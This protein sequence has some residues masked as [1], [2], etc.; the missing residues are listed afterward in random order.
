MHT[1]VPSRILCKYR[2]V[3]I[4]ILQCV[5]IVTVIATTNIDESDRIVEDLLSTTTTTQTASTG[6]RYNSDDG[7]YQR[8]QQQLPPPSSF[9]GASDLSTRVSSRCWRTGIEIIQAAMAPSTSSSFYSSGDTNHDNNSRM[10]IATTFCAQMTELEFKRLALEIAFC[11]MQDANKS[12]YQNMSIQKVCTT[13]TTTTSMTMNVETIQMCLSHLTDIGYHT[14]TYFLPYVEI[15]CTRKTQELFLQQQ[16][17]MI[18]T[19]S[20]N[21]AHMTQQTNDQYTAHIQQVQSLLEA[22]TNLQEY[23]STELKDQFDATKTGLDVIVQDQMTAWNGHVKSMVEAI[24]ERNMEYQNQMDDWTNY[25]SSMLLQHSYEMEHHR[26]LLY[27]QEVKVQHLSNTIEQSTIHMQPLFQLQSLLIMATKGYDWVT[28]FIHFLG[29]LNIVWVVTRFRQCE[30]FR[31][32]LFGF[33]YTEAV[34]EI[35]LAF[36]VQYEILSNTDRIQYI[37]E[38]RQWEIMVVIFTYVFGIIMSLWSPHH[39]PKLEPLDVMDLRREITNLISKQC[40]VTATEQNHDDMYADP[41]Y[42]K[43]VDRNDCFNSTMQYMSQQQHLHE[44]KSPLQQQR[45]FGYCSGPDPLSTTTNVSSFRAVTVEEIKNADNVRTFRTLNLHVPDKTPTGN[46]LV[47][48]HHE[49]TSTNESGM[50]TGVNELHLI[51][52]GKSSQIYQTYPPYEYTNSYVDGL[53]STPFDSNNTA[54]TPNEMSQTSSTSQ[55]MNDFMSEC[56]SNLKRQ[57]TPLEI[58]NRSVKRIACE[59]IPHST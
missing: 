10:D 19:F 37:T 42:P 15:L 22:V 36:G 49:T 47:V 1:R 39:Q 13:T 52:Y 21:Y 16:Q 58:N 59:T 12:M 6:R 41:T 27:D 50:D 33:I 5:G 55:C 57:A 31:S 35:V 25:Q 45:R 3:I 46:V 9:F 28:F 26:Q 38:L 23:F 48:D 32:Y 2:Y 54:S 11:H 29:T 44:K 4:A 18:Y 24:Y 34:L 20:N 51:D 30:K 43:N 17:E 14:Y 53:K 56:Q 7:E 8:Q 40:K